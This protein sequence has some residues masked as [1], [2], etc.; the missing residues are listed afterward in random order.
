MESNELGHVHR[1]VN[2][3]LSEEVALGQRFQHGEGTSQEAGSGEGGDVQEK[4]WASLSVERKE[5][6]RQGS[7]EDDRW[8]LRGPAGT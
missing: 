5:E 4:I 3:G 1:M 2:Q 7:T 8:D 6:A